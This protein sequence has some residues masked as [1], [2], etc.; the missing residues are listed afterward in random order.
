[1]PQKHKP[2][3]HQE[4]V[5]K[6]YIKLMRSS[7][8]V[9][10]KMHKHLAEYNLTVSQ[11]GVLEALYSLG[12][13]CQKEI[14]KKILKSDGNITMVIDKLEKRDLAKRERNMNDRRYI[15]VKLT[16]KG[17]ELMDQLFPLHAKIAEQIFSVLTPEELEELGR[18][19]KIL[20]T[21]NICVD[22][23]TKTTL[24]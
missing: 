19:L 11:F 18:M 2:E 5:L 24:N 16:N 1:M 10:A 15:T 12:P 14:G 17:E 9:T 4:L 3:K 20:G 23:F 13:L 7:D 8:A 6:A 22:Q 21:S